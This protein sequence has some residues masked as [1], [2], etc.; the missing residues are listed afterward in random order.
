MWG[1]LIAGLAGYGIARAVDNPDR[2]RAAAESARGEYHRIRTAAKAMRKEG[3]A[4]GRTSNVERFVER[5]TKGKK[6]ERYVVLEAKAWKGSKGPLFK[7]VG[8]APTRAAAMDMAQSRSKATSFVV[9]DKVT[10][11]SRQEWIPRDYRFGT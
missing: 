1:Y 3:S 4:A 5:A 10:K 6:T 8:S 9:F 11:S 7:L 2:V